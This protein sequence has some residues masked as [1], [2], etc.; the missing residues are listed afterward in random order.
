MKKDIDFVILWVDNSDIKWLN[1]KKIY[2]SSI[3]IT[4]TIN[5]YRDMGTLRYWFRG[6]EKFTPWVNNIYFITYG[7]LPSWLNIENPKLKI[8]K[9]EDYIPLEYLPTYNSN[10]IELNLHRISDLSENFVLFNDDFFIIDKMKEEDFFKKNL[11]VEEFA[12]NINMPFGYDEYFSHTAL[13]N[14]GIVNNHFSKR[15]VMKKNI[16]KYINLKYGINNI[17]TLCLLPWKNFSLIYD[18]HLPVAIKKSQ[19]EELWNIEPEAFNITSKNRFRKATD[20]NQY[21]IRYFQL[22][23]GEFIPRRHNIGKMY[24][25]SKCNKVE[26]VTAFSGLLELTRR[27]KVTTTQEELFG[28]IIVEKKKNA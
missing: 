2:D 12:E 27:D 24:T 4:D 16:F 5:R 18:P 19:L 21:L 25:L 22:L 6:I 10:V 8:I 28:D 11:P 13:N 20:I 23:K 15:N 14:I 17:R 1:E 9:H 7:H 3:N 26:V